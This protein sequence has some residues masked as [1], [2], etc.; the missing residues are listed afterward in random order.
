MKALNSPRVALVVIASIFILPLVLAWLM[1]SGVIDFKL[2]STRNL[3]LLVEPP[4]PLSWNDLD[5]PGTG[6]DSPA[7]TFAGH[8]LVLHAVPGTCDASCIEAIVGLRQVHRAAG[9]YRSRIRL[10][11]LVAAPTRELTRQLQAIY[12]DFHLLDS[13]SD[14]LWETLGQAAG[15]AQP[16]V[17]A[18][19]GTFLVDP[20]GRIMMY[21]PPD[22]DPNDLRQDLKRLLTWSKLDDEP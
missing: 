20:M 1:F 19:G 18:A 6:R 4:L 8:W 17:A 2:A 21:Y 13:P 16:A 10:G 5:E 3:G 7:D 12:H 22:S 11:L 9:R 14:R 15:A